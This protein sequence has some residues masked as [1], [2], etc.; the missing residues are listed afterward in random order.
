MRRFMNLLRLA[1]QILLTASIV[2]PQTERPT[3]N[4]PTQPMIRVDVNLRQVDLVVTDAKGNHVSDLQAADFQL[5]E[6]GEPRQITNLSWVEVT[7]PPSGARLA[8]L[9]EKPSLFEKLVGLPRFR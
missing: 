2:F 3:D 1:G 7:P 4:T 5:L 6:D 9:N 8:A